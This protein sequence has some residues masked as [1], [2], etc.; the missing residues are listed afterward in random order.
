MSEKPASPHAARSYSLWLVLALVGLD[1]F[2]TLAYL[3]SIAVEAAERMA[4]LAALGVVAVTL[5][6]AL[7][8]YLYVV[9][10]SPHG[11]GAT[12]LLERRVHGWIGKGLI[13]ILLGFVATDFVITRTLSVADAAKHITHNAYWQANVDQVLQQKESLRAALPTILQG[14]FFEFW[15]EQLVLTVLLSLLGFAL[16]AFLFRGINR[17][18]LLLA[19]AVVLLYLGLTGLIVGS[20]L[21]YLAQY[22]DRLDSW[23][24]TV[25]S[26]AGV[27]R[28]SGWELMAP[29][30]LMALVTFPQMALG[31]SGFEL[32]MTSAP[33]VRGSERDDPALPRTRIRK[34]RFLLVIAALI[35]AVFLIGSVLVVTLLVPPDTVTTG[36]AR[37]RALAYL[38]HGGEFTN[39]AKAETL[40]PLFGD[41]FG[42]VYDLS[43]V[44]ILCL[45]GA[46][47]TVGIRDLVP[48][49]L[50][51]YGMELQWAHKIGVILHLFNVVI[52]IVI[53][54]FR[55]SV[56]AQQ[57]AYAS[58]VLALLTGA[59][60]AAG[61]DLSA[62][63]RGS[64]LR[65]VFLLPFLAITG[66]FLTLGGLT[67]LIN[68]SGLAIAMIFVAVLVV[69][70]LISRYV[71]STELRFEGFE[72]ANDQTRKRW[73]E[74]CRLDFQVLVPHK[75]GHTS[76]AEAEKA[77]RRRHR[78]GADVPI[79]FIEAEVGDPSDFYQKPLMLI[80]HDSGTEVVKVLRC[81]S[82]AHVLAA[83]GLQFREVGQP[84]EIH[85]GWSDESP[86]AA[87]LHFLFLG[88]G[89]IPWMVHALLRK[90][91]RD[92]A[93]RP[94]VIIG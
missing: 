69:T 26:G 87:N 45:A 89:N 42:T 44:L 77:I 82:I 84:P 57:W 5:F 27:E 14:Q 53:L 63:W 17:P 22:P 12:G 51:R 11:Q 28:L 34:T 43:T 30:A 78:L 64:W 58:S 80:V 81:A 21:T 49:F 68:P 36:A 72:F 37:H 60:V 83:I 39:A 92:P 38:A 86:V 9:G 70:G 76:L 91:E 67:L 93:R 54:A 75:P 32:S 50:A 41:L 85:F 4:P 25:Q 52:L 74:I 7:P 23:W 3:P 13:L 8:V 55:A 18:F 79:I 47:V 29:L 46:S 19:G 10:R 48:P 6:A 88:Q 56:S 61:L 65:L 94:R 73:E 1:Y 35:M 90:A 31:L 59:S 66:L 71:R 20:G 16:Y 40:S 33:L 15:T 2:S 24:E 62:R